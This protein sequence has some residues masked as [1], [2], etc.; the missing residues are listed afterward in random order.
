M[1]GDAAPCTGEQSVLR[2]IACKTLSSLCSNKEFEIISV[3]ELAQLHAKDLRKGTLIALFEWTD[4]NRGHHN[5]LST[6]ASK[7]EQGLFLIRHIP[8]LK[9]LY[10]DTLTKGRWLSNIY[11]SVVKNLG[12]KNCDEGL[13][14]S[15]PFHASVAGQVQSTWSSCPVPEQPA[16]QV[17]IPV[18]IQV[19]ESTE[20]ATEEVEEESDQFRTD[21]Q[22]K[23]HGATLAQAFEDGRTFTCKWSI[24]EVLWK[25]AMLKLPKLILKASTIEGVRGFGVF[26]LYPIPKGQP[27]TLYGGLVVPK[28]VAKALRAQNKGYHTHMKGVGQAETEDTHVLIG[29]CTEELPLYYYLVNHFMG[30]LINANKNTGLAVNVK[31]VVLEVNFTHP[32]HHHARVSKLLLYTAL[33]PAQERELPVDT[34]LLSS[35]DESYWRETSESH[36]DE[37]TRRKLP[38]D[39]LKNSARDLRQFQREDLAEERWI[40]KQVM[41]GTEGEGG[42]E[43]GRLG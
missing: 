16:P 31:E 25:R 5:D 37:A 40:Q 10:E 3:Q 7:S 39:L 20:T 19:L 35:Y 29:H 30:S 22:E 43:E 8:V 4:A 27:L 2:A 15:A 32:Y 6:H 23:L 11:S 18:Q 36:H 1:A 34:E 24:A 33:P 14:L 21:A 17:Q 38:E 42:T 12:R 9:S 13:Y 26:T 28:K 41:R